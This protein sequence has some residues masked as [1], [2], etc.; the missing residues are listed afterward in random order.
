MNS[1]KCFYLLTDQHIR[2]TLT[3]MNIDL[4]YDS[5]ILSLQK[6][7]SNKACGP[8]NIAPRLL[9]IAGHTLIP[10]LFSLYSM[11]ALSSIVPSTWKLARSSA[12]YK[13]D[14]E[15]DKQNYRPISLLCVPG[16]LVETQVVITL[17]NHIEHHNFSINHQWAYKKDILPSYYYLR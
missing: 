6:L 9:K 3:V 13:K 16:K 14:D 12:M 1:S 7:K 8:D 10:S 2:V 4:T 15:T 17:T 11:S 5:I